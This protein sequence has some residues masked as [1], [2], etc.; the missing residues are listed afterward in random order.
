MNYMT[1]VDKVSSWSPLKTN[2]KLF[3]RQLS[4]KTEQEYQW[5]K[6]WKRLWVISTHLLSSWSLFQP[7][8]NPFLH[9]SK[10][11]CAWTNVKECILLSRGFPGG[12]EKLWMGRLHFPLCH[13]NTWKKCKSACSK[14]VIFPTF[15]LIWLS[16]TRLLFSQQECVTSDWGRTPSRVGLHFFHESLMILLLT[17]SNLNQSTPVEIHAN[18][19]TVPSFLTKR[20]VLNNW[21]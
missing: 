7:S 14:P 13:V 5:R 9:W 1:T 21:M 4:W 3:G 10:Q 16:P 8:I 20:F 19:S 15:L 12:G 6:K 11:S 17:L 18:T 2:S